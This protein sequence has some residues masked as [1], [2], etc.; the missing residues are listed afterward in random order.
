[1]GNPD[2]RR[3][4]PQKQEE[5]VRGKECGGKRG[6]NKRQK[7]VHGVGGKKRAERSH[8]GKGGGK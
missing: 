2:R 8:G 1:M 4:R 3:Q 7:Q 6:M 5:K